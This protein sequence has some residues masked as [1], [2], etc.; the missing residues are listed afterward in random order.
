MSGQPILG[1][2]NSPPRHP[3][4]AANHR[5]TAPMPAQKKPWAPNQRWTPKKTR[6]DPNI[7]GTVDGRN[8][9]SPGMVKNPINN[10]TITILG[11]AGFCP[12]TGIL[13]SKIHMFT[14]LF[15]SYWFFCKKETHQFFPAEAPSAEPPGMR[16][17]KRQSFVGQSMSRFICL[18][19]HQ[20]V[21]QLLISEPTPC[22]QKTEA[23]I[24]LIG[25]TVN[26]KMFTKNL[27]V[28][29]SLKT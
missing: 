13:T 16:V 6:G 12:S 20:G 14:G 18:S 7:L 29:S 17:S 9:A 5:A 22:F 15:F 10:G 2:K 27:C 26:Y 25:K 24:N 4:F 19:R 23:I 11:G 1:E 21:M 28:I 3:H 8:P